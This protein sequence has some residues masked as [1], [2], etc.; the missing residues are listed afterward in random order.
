M[1]LLLRGLLGDHDVKW[2]IVLIAPD[3]GWQEQKPYI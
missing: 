3:S 2:I 1:C